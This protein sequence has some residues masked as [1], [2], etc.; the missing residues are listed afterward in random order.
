VPRLVVPESL[1]STDA[2]PL[3]V[4]L[5][6]PPNA[7]APSRITSALAADAANEADPLGTLSTLPDFWVIAPEAEIE[8]VEAAAMLG[9]AMPPVWEMPIAPVVEPIVLNV[10]TAVVSER[11]VEACRP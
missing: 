6:V 7:F 1:I 9:R 3:T 11:P 5:I 4:T 8:S 10:V 2:V